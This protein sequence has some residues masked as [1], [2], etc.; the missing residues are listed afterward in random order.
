MLLAMVPLGASA[1]LIQ[2]PIGGVAPPTGCTALL[3]ATGVVPLVLTGT[4]PAT[5]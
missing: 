5:C 4:L 3:N 1:N 2:M